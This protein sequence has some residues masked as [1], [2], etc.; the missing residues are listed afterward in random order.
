ML[1]NILATAAI[2][3]AVT[4]GIIALNAPV[5]AS[6]DNTICS[7]KAVGSKNTANNTDS[8]FKVAGNTVTAT[9]IVTGPEGCTQVVT[10]ASWQAPD[11]DKGRPYNLQ[12]LY[13][14]ATGTYGVGAHTISVE[15]PDCFYQIDLVRG[16]KP[17]GID[18][19]PVYETGR[20][21][22]SLHGGTKV[23]EEKKPE[24]PVTTPPVSTT[25]TELPKTGAGNVLGIFA[26]STVLG[27]A[28][29]RLVTRRS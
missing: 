24:P 20:M 15:A 10:L 27:A 11:A 2:V 5:Y 28:V 9:F 6:S 7:V 22:G 25:P 13:K 4:G 16:S 14:Y 26:A 21:M 23:C 3:A 17:T 29:H 12:K 8:R 19:G 18:G 1:K